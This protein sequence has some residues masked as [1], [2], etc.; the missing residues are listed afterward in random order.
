MPVVIIIFM[1]PERAVLR[2]GSIG[3]TAAYGPAG[4][5]LRCTSRIGGRAGSTAAFPSRHSMR[6]RL[7][8]SPPRQTLILRLAVASLPRREP[9]S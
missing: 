1:I 5:V 6:L 7:H 3:S 2:V 4:I 9:T 8:V